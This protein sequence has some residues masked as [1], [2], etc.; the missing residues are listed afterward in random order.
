MCPT[1]S[2]IAL[3]CVPESVFALPVGNDTNFLGINSLSDLSGVDIGPVPFG[4]QRNRSPKGVTYTG[5][6]HITQ[7]FVDFTADAFNLSDNGNFPASFFAGK[8]LEKLESE[9]LVAQHYIWDR[10]IVLMG[11]WRNDH[12]R[13]TS[14]NAPNSRPEFLPSDSDN[15]LDPTY[16]AGPQ[17]SDLETDADEDTTSWAATVHMRELLGGWNFLPDGV[18]LSFYASEADNFQPTSG[19]VTVSE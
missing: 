8:S 14:I 13:S 18:N 9:V 15:T 17:S 3:T 11:T 5:W 10:A 1:V 19:N 4:N 2:S 12:V 16:L 7:E 6:N